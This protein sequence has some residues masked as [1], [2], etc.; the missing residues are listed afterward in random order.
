MDPDDPF[1]RMDP[2]AIRRGSLRTLQALF[3]ELFGPEPETESPG[4][5]AEH[6]APAEH[7]DE[8]DPDSDGN[9]MAHKAGSAGG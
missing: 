7:D 6:P 9:G 5:S 8:S 4:Q 2:E 3:P 1:A